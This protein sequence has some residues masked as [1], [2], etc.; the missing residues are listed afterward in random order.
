MLKCTR[1]LVSQFIKTKKSL[2]ILLVYSIH[3]K[4][5]PHSGDIGYPTFTPEMRY[6]FRLQQ[7]IRNMAMSAC[8]FDDGVGIY[9]MYMLTLT[10]YR[11][12][13]QSHSSLLTFSKTSYRKES[14]KL[15]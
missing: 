9:F 5:E 3:S 1:S 11:R 4:R 10:I 7:G 2:V 15:S 14:L 6:S 12:K 13:N 8:V